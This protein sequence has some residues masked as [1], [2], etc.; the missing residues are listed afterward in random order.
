MKQCLIYGFVLYKYVEENENFFIMRKSLRIE[1]QVA[2]KSTIIDPATAD[3]I[4]LLAS[5]GAR[6]SKLSLF[7]VLNK[8]VTPSGVRLL[9]SNLYQPPID[10]DVIQDRLCLVEELI[11]D[12]G[13]FNSLRNIISRFPDLDPVLNLCVK[14]QETKISSSQI[15]AKID[16]MISLKQILQLLPAFTEILSKSKATICVQAVKKFRNHVKNSSLLLEMMYL[17]LEES[18]VGIKGSSSSGKFSRAMAVKADVNGLL[19]LARRTFCDYV[20]QMN[21][22]VN[23]LAEAHQAPMK[24]EWKANKGWFIQIN[25]QK[26]CNINLNK[27]PEEFIRVVKT[28]TGVTFVTQDF[29]AKDS[30][31]KDSLVEINKMSDAIL[32]ELL[33][34][35]REYIGFLYLLSDT[36]S[37]IDMLV[38]FANVSMTEDYTKPEFG[39]SLIIRGGRHPILERICVDVTSNDTKVDRLSRLQILTGPNMSGKSTYLRQVLLL[40]VM[41]QIGCYVPAQ[42]ATVRITDRIFSRVTNRDSIETNSSTFMVEMQETAFILSNM[43][44]SSLVIID[45]LGRG[46]SV[47]EGTA[48]CWAV[49]EALLKTSAFVFLATHFTQMPALADLH[50]CVEN[51]HFLTRVEANQIVHTHQLV[52]GRAPET[53][54]RGGD[55]S[56]DCGEV[57]Y[58][59]ELASRSALPVKYVEKARKIS[60][61]IK[62]SQ[63]NIVSVNPLDRLCLDHVIRMK[64]LANSG[65]PIGDLQS[66]LKDIKISFLMESKNLPEIKEARVSRDCDGKVDQGEQTAG[67]SGDNSAQLQ[68]GHRHQSIQSVEGEPKSTKVSVFHV[69]ELDGPNFTKGSSESDQISRKKNSGIE[70]EF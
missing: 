15:E 12:M 32:N 64:K 58:G 68:T 16:R 61:R 8:C 26:N 14:R 19:D 5:L 6:K 31:A 22:E 52:K 48:I 66:E 35:V 33:N 49:A 39:D 34:E 44:Q 11:N 47:E 2:E 10:L 51:S 63:D 29:A 60:K 17:V 7:G 46:T 67:S 36:I 70:I 69:E 23:A 20:E 54:G 9:R 43:G 41:A 28:K 65:L 24:L 59:L 1:Y 18:N 45:E 37:N 27:L 50:P 42:F 53:R 21:S 56:A 4:E 57:S 25:N 30:L 62:H 38:S 55:D 13:F 40:T 3:H